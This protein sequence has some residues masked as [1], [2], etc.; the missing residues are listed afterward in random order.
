MDTKFE[1]F[2]SPET[3]FDSFKSPLKNEIHNDNKK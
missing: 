3:K 2:K 1:T